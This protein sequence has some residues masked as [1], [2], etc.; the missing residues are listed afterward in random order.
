M[1]CG[2]ISLRTDEVAQGSM[3]QAEAAQVMSDLFKDLSQAIHEIDRVASQAYILSENTVSIAREGSDTV[4]HSIDGMQHVKATMSLLERDSAKIGEIINIIDNIAE[5]TNLLALNA[6]IEAA[7][8][9]TEGRGFAVVAEE[10]RKLAERSSN[11]TRE[12]TDI[13]KLMQQNTYK[14]VTAVSDGVIQSQKTFEAFDQ[15]MRIVGETSVKVNE[16][17]SA[18][19]AQT[20]QT[21]KVM[22]AIESV[23][24]VSEETAAS[25]EETASSS[26]SLEYLAS[27]LSKTV[28]KFRVE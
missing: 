6:A 4:N 3:N 13:I 18:S 22:E 9:G 10:V 5:Q 27:E 1:A 7:R 15:I 25:A 16:I 17:S 20:N 14:S 28:A 24:A 11:A 26:Q 23:A 8:A 2:E 21:A 19:K 12:I